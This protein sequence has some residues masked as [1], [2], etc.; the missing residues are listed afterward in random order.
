MYWLKLPLYTLL[1]LWI[2]SYTYTLHITCVFITLPSTFS[3]RQLSK[4]TNCK[5]TPPD[6]TSDPGLANFYQNSPPPNTKRQIHKVLKT[7][8][9][10]KAIQS[11]SSCQLSTL[12]F[13]G[14]YL[15]FKFGSTPW[16]PA[17]NLIQKFTACL[18]QATKKQFHLRNQLLCSKCLSYYKLS[19]TCS[20]QSK[21]Q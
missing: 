19:Y 4:S 6:I 3:F 11:L 2:N 1:L 8:L 13:E 14:C 20:H 12:E 17:Y 18:T 21:T 7:S 5:M 16:T 15:S 9:S 10:S